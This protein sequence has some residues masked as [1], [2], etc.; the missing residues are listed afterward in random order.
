MGRLL[1]WVGLI[2]AAYWLWRR[3]MRPAPA[4]PGIEEAA[5]MVRC[6]HC[7]VHTPRMNA[8]SQGSQWFCSQVHLEQG[9][10]RS[11]R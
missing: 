5:P 4:K 9:A 6:A 3:F 11:D 10:T 2:F 1:I 7:G 8:V